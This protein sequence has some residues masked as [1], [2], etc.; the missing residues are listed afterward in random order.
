M[1]KP[2]IYVHRIGAADKVLLI[3]I[4]LICRGELKTGLNL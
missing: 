1:N 3:P 2:L 4:P